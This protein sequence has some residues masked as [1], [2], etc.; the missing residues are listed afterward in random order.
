MSLIYVRLLDPQ[1]ATYITF[2][3]EHSAPT[4]K[5]RDSHPHK[6]IIIIDRDQ[7]TEP[8]VRTFRTQPFDSSE[9]FTWITHRESISAPNTLPDTSIISRPLTRKEISRVKM[10]ADGY[11]KF[12]DLRYADMT[13]AYINE[14]CEHFFSNVYK[15]M[16][17]MC[18]KFML[19]VTY[20]DVIQFLNKGI[21]HTRET[22]QTLLN[23]TTSTCI[24]RESSWAKYNS[25]EE[26]F[27]AVTC[28]FGT[29]Y[30]HF[31][32]C[33]RKGYGIFNACDYVKTTKN[34]DGTETITY[35]KDIDTNLYYLTIGHLLRWWVTQGH[36]WHRTT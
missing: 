29:V 15:E 1:M 23:T 3:V 4:D 24:I 13:S 9:L 27:F 8:T 33:H 2:G 16:T 14:L 35:K 25:A 7:S 31:V 20:S 36:V 19:Y 5:T 26:E 12:P 6:T 10:Y 28:K 32:Y 17:E 18:Q 21:M 22:A 30:D 34:A 11:A